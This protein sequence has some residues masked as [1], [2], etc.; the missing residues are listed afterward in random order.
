MIGDFLDTGVSP[1]SKK[2]DGEEDGD[3]FD[4]LE[5]VA[6]GQ[7]LDAIDPSDQAYLDDDGDIGDPSDEDEDEEQ[8]DIVAL[9]DQ[10]MQRKV[11]LFKRTYSGLYTETVER[12]S[13]T[14]GIAVR[15]GGLC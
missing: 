14:N 3:G 5:Q 15:H 8:E 12:L 1:S 4:Q 13:S 10:A 6:V 9:P 7:E 2:A 11:L